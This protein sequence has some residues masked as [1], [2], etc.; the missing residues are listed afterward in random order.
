MARTKKVET[1]LAR[2]MREEGRKQV[3]LADRVGVD[4]ATINR[5]IHGL[6]APDATRQAIAD[7]LN[8]SVSELWPEE[9]GQAA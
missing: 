6:H 2:I 9:R 4:P 8:R 1:P 7:A 5:I 3:W